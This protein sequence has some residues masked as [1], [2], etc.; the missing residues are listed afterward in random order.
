MNLATE[1]SFNK[2]RYALRST[3][4]ANLPWSCSHGLH[5]T[6]ASARSSLLRFAASSVFSTCQTGTVWAER[7]H[8]DGWWVGVPPHLVEM[9]DLESFTGLKGEWNIVSV[10]SPGHFDHMA[11]ESEVQFFTRP[12]PAD[13]LYPHALMLSS[14][15]YPVVSAK[16]M[17]WA[18]KGAQEW[19]SDFLEDFLD[20]N[21]ETIC[22]DR[23]LP[24]YI[25]TCIYKHIYTPAYTFYRSKKITPI[26]EKS[27]EYLHFRS[28]HLV[29]IPWQ[30]FA[31]SIHPGIGLN[32]MSTGGMNRKDQYEIS[33]RWF[34][35][36]WYFDD[37]KFIDEHW[38]RV[39][40][41][42]II[43]KPSSPINI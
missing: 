12:H 23:V 28:R 31:K 36:W 41:A 43:F 33:I 6:P 27:C 29:V 1:V 38:V 22:S 15:R 11:E 26:F 8:G 16:Q 34:L 40:L 24:I 42:S 37:S 4:H 17:S 7:S 3:C 13:L 25:Y 19:S 5:Q 21:E 2:C 10:L 18:Q 39:A 30:E 20:L 14:L 35:I 9:V 32:T